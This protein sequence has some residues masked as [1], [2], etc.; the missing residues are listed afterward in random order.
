MAEV[1]ITDAGRSQSKRPK[2]QSDCV[3]RAVALTCGYDYDKAYDLMAE[4]GRKSSRSMPKKNWQKW[5]NDHFVKHSFPAV[6]GEKRM[7]LRNFAGQYDTGK[8]FV[9]MAGHVVSVIDGVIM[10]DFNPDLE[11]CV[12]AVWKTA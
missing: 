12:Y 11:M 8:W 6:K 5:M 9:Q 4:A 7:N 3:V 1:I 10:D 2:Q